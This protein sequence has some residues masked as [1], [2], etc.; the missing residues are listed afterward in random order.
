MEQLAFPW[1]KK[2]PHDRAEGHE[3]WEVQ[4]TDV[5]G[6]APVIHYSIISASLLILCCE[7][8]IREP[9]RTATALMVAVISAP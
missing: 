4:K 3:G 8:P 9:I 2:N 1:I 5:K 6:V 7:M